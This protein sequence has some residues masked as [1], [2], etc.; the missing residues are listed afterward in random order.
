M[1]QWSYGVW[2]RFFYLGLALFLLLFITWPFLVSHQ[3]PATPFLLVPCVVSA[4]IAWHGFRLKRVDL[5][6]HKTLRV[7]DGFRTI[8]VSVENVRE[9]TQF[10][11]LRDRPITI[12]FHNTTA[13]GDRVTFLPDDWQWFRFAFWKEDR[14]VNDFRAAVGLPRKAV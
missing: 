5:I 1:I 12:H 10:V 4:G 7:S 2:V 13:F 3:L 6:G 11:W 14:I 9:I 8:D